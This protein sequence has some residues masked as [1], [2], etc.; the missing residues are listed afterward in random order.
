M[1]PSDPHSSLAALRQLKEMLDAGTITPQEFETLKRQ[2]VFGAEP[3]LPL[4]PL[5][6]NLAEA[7]AYEVP[8]APAPVPEAT[9]AA[10]DT[11][12]PNP[13]ELPPPPPATPDWLAA[14]AP[15]LLAH[16]EADLP[17]LEERR[18]P[19]NLVFAIGGLLVFLGVVAYLMIGRPA[20]PNEHLTSGTQTAAD[21]AATV[22][23]VGPQA[24]QLSL[25]PAPAPD[26]VRVAPQERPAPA[27]ASQFKA[28]SVAA[29]APSSAPATTTTSID[30]AVIKKP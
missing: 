5:T 2:V 11:S 7:P 9:N 26:T 20:Q 14:A 24:E 3:A 21:S 25:P 19:L 12:A 1:I 6:E 30:S 28:D 8:E 29:P 16:E 4:T 22:P 10:Y 23:E 17:P 15:S 13:A 27:P 18:N